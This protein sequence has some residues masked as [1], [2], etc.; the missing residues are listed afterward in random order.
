MQ[1]SAHL[2]FQWLRFAAIAAQ[3][4]PLKFAPTAAQ[5]RSQLLASQAVEV[6]SHRFTGP[7]A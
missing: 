4:Q 6:C 5:V 2:P 7:A 3:A 1:P